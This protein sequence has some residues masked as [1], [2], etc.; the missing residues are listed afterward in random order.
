M[1]VSQLEKEFIEPSSPYRAKPFWAWNDKLEETELRRQIRIF[2]QMG[3]GGYFMHSRVGLKTPYLSEEWFDLIRDCIDEGAKTGTEAW[4]YDEDRWPSGAAGGLVTKDPKYQAKFLV[5]NRHPQPERFSWPKEYTALMYGATF[6]DDKITWYKKLDQNADIQILPQGAEILEFVLKN[7]PASPWFNDGTHL[8]TLSREAVARFIEVTHEKYLR[9]VGTYFSKEVPGMFTDEPNGGPV[10]RGFYGHASAIPWTGEF[11]QRFQELFDYDI[12]QH[13]PEIYFDLV[14]K[15]FSP[16]RY[17]YHRCKTRLFVE[18]FM[19]QIGD[20]CGRNNLMFT[21]HVLEEQPI[22]QNVSVVGAAMQA[23]PYMQAPG[24]D[25][26]TQY[27]LEYISAK[28]VASVARQTGRKW[29]L[30]ELYGCTGWDTTFETYK[31]SGDWQAVL[32][33]TMRCPHLSWYSMAGEAKRDYPASIHFHSPWWK[34]YKFVEDYFS[35]LNVVL[36]EGEAVCDL[37]VIHPVESYYLVYGPNWETDARIKKMDKEYSDLVGWLLAGHLDFDFADEHLLVEFQA[38]LDRD[39]AGPV[40]RIG[41]MKYR[42]VLVP[43]MITLRKTTL[44]LLKQFADAG[45]KVVFAGSAAELLDANASEEVKSFAQGKIVGFSASDIVN[46]LQ[47]KTRRVGIRDQQGQEAADIFYQLRKI[48]DDWAVFMVNTNRQTGY[49][50]LSVKIQLELP[51][52]GQIQ[53]WDAVT[54]QKSKLPGE[55][56]YRSASFKLDIPASG[57][58]LVIISSQPQDLPVLPAPRPTAKQTVIGEEGWSLLLDDYNVVV[59]D[60]P[61]C[62]A[63]AEGKKKYT[64]TKMEIL[65]LDREL[66]EYM[67]LKPRG[68]DMVQPWVDADKPIG[69]T[70]QL[71]LNYKFNVKVI[72]T[73]PVLLALEQP[74]RWQIKI[75]D[76]KV[77]LDMISGWWVDPAIKTLLLE[78]TLLL[79]GKNL[80]TLEGQFDRLTDLETLFILGAFGAETDGKNVSITKLPTKLEPGSWLEQGLPFYS[81]NV[82]YR[83][84]FDFQPS[85][86]EKYLFKLPKFTGT[87]A[88]ITFNGKQ[89]FLVAWPEY[90]F[91]CTGLLQPGKNTIDIK[92]LGSR[93]N[94]FG[95][96]HLAVEKPWWTGPAEFHYNSENPQDWQDEFKLKP[97]GL[98]E[99]PVITACEA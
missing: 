90:Q 39:Q 52:G 57:S 20:W 45:G 75:N 12:L 48:G 50:Q 94:A 42:A 68:G 63:Q 9:E 98:L 96:L 40:L 89:P 36:S 30:S 44:D 88:E 13:I 74:Q 61:D 72:P 31:S 43:P 8:D 80:L 82:I 32:G 24:I 17:H 2:K 95:P 35:R 23:Y 53:I 71:S 86:G 54:G 84:G 78:P 49:Q 99:L 25:I 10:F 64:K 77:S 41:N 73:S 37:A 28:Q 21:G 69:P 76:Q 3:F 92:I 70:A 38:Q 59:L 62:L 4:L 85:Y 34:Q 6:E 91:D 65:Q 83:T 67:G 87:A 26:L 7:A 14:N 93:R 81:G 60:R 15:P 56:T 1:S 27:C 5:L 51:K 18:N 58:R 79:R 33:I 22:S 29:V 16:A 46:A 11:A 97:Y 66:R 47:E 55:L 19:K